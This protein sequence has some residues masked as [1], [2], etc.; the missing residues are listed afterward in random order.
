[1]KTDDGVGVGV[2]V[3]A[4]TVDGEVEGEDAV[5]DETDADGM[6]DVDVEPVV[7]AWERA[8]AVEVHSSVE[9]QHVMAPMK[10]AVG[11]VRV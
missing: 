4:V 2:G 9:I 8:D 6:E 11:D 10:R 5:P 7:S 3:V 1:M